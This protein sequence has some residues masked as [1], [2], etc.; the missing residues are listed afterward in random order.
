MTPAKPSKLTMEVAQDILANAERDHQ[1]W[2]QDLLTQGRPTHQ[3]DLDMQ[4]TPWLV[5]KVRASDHYAQNLYA[6]M[7]NQTW[8]E[9]AVWP[10]L[11][12]DTWSCSWRSAGAIVARL[13]ESGNYLDWYCSGMAD[14]HRMEEWRN[15]GFV[16]ES[17]ITDEIRADLAQIGW[18]PIDQ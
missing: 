3:M 16:G 5:A 11:K 13:R 14:G 2:Q 12:N 4:L 1:E 18:H 17:D 9:Q 7:C 8:Q 6:A 10:I 15:R